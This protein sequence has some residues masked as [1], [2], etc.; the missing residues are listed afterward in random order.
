MLPAPLPHLHRGGLAVL[1]YD[2]RVTTSP[3]QAL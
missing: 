3:I 2:Q 1:R